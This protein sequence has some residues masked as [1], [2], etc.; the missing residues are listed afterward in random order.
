MSTLINVYTML[1]GVGT[2]VEQLQAFT[3]GEE[4]R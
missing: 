2:T 3:D 1:F 4:I